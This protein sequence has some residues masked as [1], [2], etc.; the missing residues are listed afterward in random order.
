[1][2][3]EL[4]KQ[5]KDAGFPQ[6]ENLLVGQADMNGRNW[7]EPK[8]LVMDEPELVESLGSENCKKR[9]AYCY[10]LDFLDSD[11]GKAL[12]VYIPTLEQLIEAC[13]DGYMVVHRG[14]DG[15]WDICSK[16][17]PVNFED[18]QYSTPIEAV[19]RLWLALNKR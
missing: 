11:E 15:L 17:A 4:A 18:N 5:L 3:Y 16:D 19:A 1:M 10:T 12:T 6:H 14:D 9:A 13:G 8:H 7:I 2:N